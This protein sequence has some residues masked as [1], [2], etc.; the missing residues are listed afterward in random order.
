MKR[1]RADTDTTRWTTILIQQL[2]CQEKI[3]FQ[4]FLKYF[5]SRYLPISGDENLFGPDKAECG[6]ADN[7]QRERAQKRRRRQ[8]LRQRFVFVNKRSTFS[9]KNEAC[10]VRLLAAKKKRMITGSYPHR[11]FWA[12]S[13][14]LRGVWQGRQRSA[15]M[16]TE[17]PP[18]PVPA[19]TFCVCVETLY[20]FFR[21][22][23]YSTST[24]R[25]ND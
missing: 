18:S 21:K 23:S 25:K 4:S 10:F 2:T 6:G 24:G 8:C 5:W 19:T 12:F 14:I 13:W 11:D 15:R 9:E 16:R 3:A 1:G 20:F 17:T 7:E 22:K